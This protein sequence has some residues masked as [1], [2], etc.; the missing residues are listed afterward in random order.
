VHDSFA[1]VWEAIADSVPDAPAV[2]QRTERGVRRA[3]WGELEDHAARLAGGLAERGV[4]PGTHVALFLHNAPEYTECFLAC[5]KLRARSAN[6]NF[7]YE[8][9]EL[10][11]L[12]ENADAEVLVYHRALADRVAAVRDSL[13]LLRVLVEVD[14][15]SAVPSV[16][17][18][19]GYDE[20]VSMAAPQPRADRSGDD[21]LLWYTGGTTG[22]PKGVLWRQGTLLEYG[23]VYAA[24]LIGRPIP[25]SA[26]DAAACARELHASATPPVALL[27]TPLVHA[28]AAYQM[29]VWLSVGGTIALLPR[30]RVDGDDV[31]ATIQRERV[32][33]LSIVG[34]V[35]L[36]RIVA[37]LER[38]EERG[39]PYDVT[40]L[41]RVHNSGA[42]VSA[43]LKD[44]FLGRGTMS[45]YDSLGSSE[46]VGFGLA[47]TASPG[48]HTTARFRLGP[49]ARI[50]TPEGR[51]VRAGSDEAGV[52]AVAHS[53]A[54]GYYK[55]PA[56][57]AT[58][59]PVIDGTQYAIPGDW[60]LHHADGTITLLGRGSGCIN[61]GGEKVW[62]EEVE[63]VL[64]THPAVTDA[65]VVGVPDTE[66]GE[67]VGAVVSLRAGD[68]PA[69]TGEHLS[70]WVGS[71]LASYKRPRRVAIV[72][73]VRR[74]TV[75][76]A[77][78]DWARASLS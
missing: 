10:V 70:A 68:G 22:L 20:L 14:D 50:L 11:A 46:A 32:T 74:T 23:A 8:A 65:I 77:D 33:L 21:L 73:E 66:W 75:G 9:S 48:E 35:V 71:R 55:D 30:G 18:A 4:G 44:A 26:A 58:T 60:A 25:V 31:C 40:S 2:V 7:R 57:S 51:D 53:T 69:P 39:E 43:E 17:G 16:P 61:T 63:E 49:R 13:P 56:R 24:D 19:L 27:T 78:Y 59:F 1:T 15:G 28:T 76:K 3:S 47:L 52:L 45:F 38:A 12:L 41:R 37:A 64:K 62:P 29:M 5:S 72:D 67:T 54:V 42:M 34:D 6:V 36:R